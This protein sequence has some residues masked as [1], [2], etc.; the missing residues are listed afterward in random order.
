VPPLFGLLLPVDDGLPPANGLLPLDSFASISN[1]P[2][3]LGKNLLETEEHQKDK[4]ALA[5]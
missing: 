5:L 3:I 2:L 1:S 4:P